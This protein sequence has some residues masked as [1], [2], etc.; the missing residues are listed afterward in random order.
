MGDWSKSRWRRRT[1]IDGDLE[2]SKRKEG[3]VPVAATATVNRVDRREGSGIVGKAANGKR[4]EKLR[5]VR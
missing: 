4:A 3:A 1:R 5:S 2:Q